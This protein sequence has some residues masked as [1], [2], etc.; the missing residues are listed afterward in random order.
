MQSVKK[1]VTLYNDQLVTSP[2]T[3]KS[4][5]VTLRVPTYTY[6]NVWHSQNH[7]KTCAINYYLF[8]FSINGAHIGMTK[9]VI[10]DLSFTI[11]DSEVSFQYL[12]QAL[13]RVL[14]YESWES[15]Y[16]QMF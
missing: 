6:L 11:F 2:T 13:E 8:H 7:P 1:G 15:Y 3:I 10:N 12:I 9:Q 14:W 16:A 5:K 4:I